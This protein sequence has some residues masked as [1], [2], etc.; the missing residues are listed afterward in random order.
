M[1]KRG[2]KYSSYPGI[3]LTSVLYVKELRKIQGEQKAVW[4]K[5]SPSYLGLELTRL[6]SILKYISNASISLC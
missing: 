3:E 1:G 5:K 2:W 4:N 6:Y